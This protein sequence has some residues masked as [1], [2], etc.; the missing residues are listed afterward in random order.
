MDDHLFPYRATETVG[1]VVHLIHHDEPQTAQRRG[2]GVEH[3]AQHLGGHHDDARRSVDV[4]VAREQ[5]D[6]VVAVHLLQLVEL[7]V[8]QRLDGRGVERLVARLEHRQ[9][10]RELADDGLAGPGGCGDEHAPPV[11]EGVA[12][13]DLEIVELEPLHLGEIGR[14]RVRGTRSGAG[15]TLRRARSAHAMGPEGISDAAA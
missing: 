10:D 1:E 9:V 5:P 7:L 15:E 14:V 2:I 13:G 3:V 6:L 11:L 8:R 4:R 12:S